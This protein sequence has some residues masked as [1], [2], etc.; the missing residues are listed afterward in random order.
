MRMSWQRSGSSSSQSTKKKSFPGKFRDLNWS[1]LHGD[2]IEELKELYND[3]MLTL[4]H[5]YQKPAIYQTTMSGLEG[6]AKMTSGLVLL[7]GLSVATAKDNW[8]SGYHQHHS[9]HLPVHGL[10]SGWGLNY[11]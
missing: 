7:N 1:A 5:G 11:I 9:N 2:N 6:A 3:V 10:Y 8:V 4:N